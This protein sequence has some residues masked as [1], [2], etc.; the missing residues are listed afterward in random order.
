MM[1]GSVKPPGRVRSSKVGPVEPPGWT[2]HAGRCDNWKIGVKLE[3]FHFLNFQAT[4][5]FSL[6]FP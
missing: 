6:Q 1:S 5:L 2:R 4:S 3:D